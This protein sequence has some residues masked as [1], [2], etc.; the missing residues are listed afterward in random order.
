MNTRISQAKKRG[1]LTKRQRAQRKPNRIVLI[2][3]EEEDAVA[4]PAPD[5]HIRHNASNN[6][7]GMHSHSTRPVQ[8]DEVPGQ[9]TANSADVDE[10][11]R[12]RVA[13]VGKRQIEEIDYEQQLSEPKVRAHPQMDEAEEEEV[14]R[15]KVGADVG[16]GGDVDGV[17]GVEGVG[18]DELQDEEDEPV[19]AGEDAVLGKGGR[20]VVL[21]DAAARGMAFGRGVEGVVEGC[22][23]EEEVGDGGGDFVEEDGLRGEFFAAGEGVEAVAAAGGAGFGHGGGERWRECEERCR[24]GRGSWVG[25]GS[26]CRSESLSLDIAQAAQ[27]APLSRA[28]SNQV[29]RLGTTI[30]ARTARLFTV[31]VISGSKL[32]PLGNPVL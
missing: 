22:D 32:A 3:R 2:G 18:V 9:R 11:R 27:H 25:E 28:A 14:V 10:A 13:E 8:G 15:D 29:P 19:D 24:T 5:E 21:P 31:H 20:V 4:Q 23:E 30:K 17:G 7:V 6:M 16:G 1:Q 12:G 26:L